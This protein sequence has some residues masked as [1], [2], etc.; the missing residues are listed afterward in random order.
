MPAPGVAASS[1]S[2]RVAVT[3]RESHSASDNHWSG[4]LFERASG[5]FHQSRRYALRVVDRI[6]GGDSFA[7]GLMFELMARRAGRRARS[8]SRWRPAP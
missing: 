1:T 8:A 3:L 2:A 7:A 4:V 5:A 6:G